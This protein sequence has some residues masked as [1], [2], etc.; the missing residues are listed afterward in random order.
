[1]IASGRGPAIPY[2]DGS[3]PTDE[4]QCITDDE[5]HIGMRLKNQT[6]VGASPASPIMS[7]ISGRGLASSLP[8]SGSGGT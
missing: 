5:E 6:L 8:A 3:V 2:A 1:M 7:S 4:E